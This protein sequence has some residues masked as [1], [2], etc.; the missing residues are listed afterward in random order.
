[1]PLPLICG[2]VRFGSAME[3]SKKK[4]VIWQLCDL[5]NK[6]LYSRH[7]SDHRVLCEGS[8][9]GDCSQHPFIKGGVFH[10]IAV[11]SS[12]KMLSGQIRKV[13]TFCCFLKFLS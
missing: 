3:R 2:R 10:A 7:L 6:L 12:D 4:H 11:D 13:L 9:S 8:S 1:M 5:C